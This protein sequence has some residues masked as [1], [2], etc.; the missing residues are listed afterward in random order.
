[1]KKI[2]FFL[3]A[4][5]FIVL[6]LV[7]GPKQVHGRDP[8][9][10]GPTLNIPVVHITDA[11][12]M[13]GEC[14][15][16]EY[17]V[18]NTVS[19]PYLSN[20]EDHQVLILRTPHHLYVCVRLLGPVG[21]PEADENA[22]L[23]IY[24][25]RLN[26]G[27]LG[28]DDMV[29]RQSFLGDPE[30]AIWDVSQNRFSG[31][32]PGGWDVVN[33]SHPGIPG[34]EFPRH[35]TSAEFRISR[36]TVGGWN[37]LVGFAVMYR[38][39]P[40]PFT[41]LESVYGWPIPG[42]LNQPQQWGNLNLPTDEITIGPTDVI[43]A[44]DGSCDFSQEWADASFVQFPSGT[45]L[46]SARAMHS[47]DDLY[48]CLVL[49]RP[50]TAVRDGPNAAVMINRNGQ[51]GEYPGPDDL[52][53]TISYNGAFS[54][55]Q[56]DGVAWNGPDPGG[57]EIAR[58]DVNIPDTN[59]WHA[60]YRISAATL[61][62]GWDRDINIGFAQQWLNFV[63]DDY[64]W[65]ENSWWWNVPN[66]WGIGHLTSSP[67]PTAVDIYPTGMEVVQSIQDLDN[68]V[69][70]VANKRTFVRVH[71]NADQAV[72]GV[73][74]RLF[75]YRDGVPLG[76]PLLPVNPAGFVNVL[77]NPNRASLNDSF[78][79]EL[80]GPWTNDGS[81]AL[82][83]EINPF[84]EIEERMYSNN[85]IY[86]PINTFQQ[87][88]PLRVRLVNY[89]YFLPNDTLVSV[90][91]FDMDMVESQ[92][93]RMYPIS[94]LIADRR[95]LIDLMI[96]SPPRADYVNSKLRWLRDVWEDQ[97][98]GALDAIYYGMVSDA[99]GRI[100]GKADG[101][102]SMV[103]SGPAGAPRLDRFAWDMDGSY[104]D[105]YAGHELGH[106][107][108]RK[109]AEFC[110]AEDGADYPYA[111]GIIGGPAN[112]MDR[113]L[114]FD[115]GDSALGLNVNV[116]PS[117]WTD[118]MSYCANEW[119]SDF[120][121]EGIHHYIQSH[122]EGGLEAVAPTMDH[123]LD[124][125]F[126]A[127]YGSLNVVEQTASIPFVS[128]QS[129]VARL[130]ERILGPYHIQLFDTADN[131]LADYPFSLVGDAGDDDEAV[132]QI[133]QIVDWVAGTR[134]IAIYSDLVDRELV[135]TAV[136]ANAPHIT[137]TERTGGDVLP[138]AGT[139]DLGWQAADNDENPLHYL[140]LYSFDDGNSWRALATTPISATL[141]IDTSQLEG[142][143]GTAVGW[144]RVI[145]ND[146]VLT[147]QAD[148]GPF[149]VEDKVPTIQ[150]SSPAPES[151]YSYG[152]I[153]T[154]EGYGSD[155]EEGSLADTQLTWHSSRDGEL[156]SG[157]LLYPELLA[158]GDHEIMLTAVD[159]AGNVVSD[160]VTITVQSAMEMPDAT[161]A[162][163]PFSLVFQAEAGAE[164]PASQRLSIR[165]S[166]SGVLNW[167]AHEN[168]P[169]L[170]LSE[171]SGSAPS[172]ITVLVDTS[173]FLQGQV[174]QSEIR[175]TS[176]GQTL[177]LPVTVQMM[178][179][180]GDN[181]I[182]YLPGIFYPGR[183]DD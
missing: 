148:T 49:F 167:M 82:R 29:V 122:F 16:E 58:A 96:D 160:T 88:N 31:A 113:F 116:I 177:T 174:I 133:A 22:I 48:I 11:P 33:Y 144:L 178:G 114:G 68:S 28:S 80:P 111:N 132:D 87:T 8:L 138:A 147:A 121:Y 79:F 27:Q 59:L 76:F 41:C 19:Y 14:L 106:A 69:L 108:G 163:A 65:P 7:E 39:Q 3:L 124:G 168:A 143:G 5:L 171:T 145:A 107:L 170:T 35:W 157:H 104:A 175:L 62:G 169:W 119:I 81:I 102:P 139:I 40:C 20:F 95:R 57:Y 64:G 17:G 103:A 99:G 89:Q 176:A 2:P 15:P 72:N 43:P 12:T 150:I 44:I 181:H 37:R 131:L 110:G 141:R 162:A 165:N 152:Q 182:I 97:G 38:F 92:L 123:T 83:A 26:D 75:G 91:T 115:V 23:S 34:Q 53:F 54:A 52:R 151:V 117:S 180:P 94:H 134:R 86:R 13:D 6:I 142:T 129:E 9:G 47:D 127:V 130:P 85:D 66:N 50:D 93:R 118:V 55:N 21:V 4:I 56:G 112:E 155:F 154:L 70:L 140:V 74:A 153:V 164:N 100:R 60:E 156:G 179:D 42:A 128:R 84:H 36:Q 137:I 166:G 32:D 24:L 98:N 136:S 173:T 172:E 67:V 51:G 46:A 63:G 120:T 30:A 61:G 125:D 71:V 161:L 45:G 135:S 126:L 78:Y 101:I 10:N 90:R 73:T 159:T 1:M 183:V 109:H 149:Q 158:V 146:G 105:F 18:A 25:D 77:P